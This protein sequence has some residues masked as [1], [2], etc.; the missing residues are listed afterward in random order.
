MAKKLI[1]LRHGNIGDEY[2]GR[3]IGASDLALSEKGT[4]QAKDVAELVLAEEPGLCLSSPM[5]RCRQT[6]DVVAAATGLKFELD[7]DLREI[8]F[9]DWE[10]MT[11]DEILRSSP[12][13]VER[14]SAFDIF[15]F[16]GGESVADFLFRIGRVAS[17]MALSPE[18]NV[19]ACTHG[20]VIR[21][22]ICYFLG[23]QARQY[24][25]FE[26]KPASLTTI[27]LFEG[28]GVLTGMNETKRR[29]F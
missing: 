18:D 26:V 28:R 15:Q 23:I 11:F 16:P 3:Y 14:W 5:G 13:H 25:L 7:G 22:L 1:L 24:I 6:A 2:H 27:E 8:D 20:G 19:L 10:G 21:S 17:R 9:G 29:G 12:V 4:R